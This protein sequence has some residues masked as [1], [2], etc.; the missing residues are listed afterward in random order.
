MLIEKYPLS[1]L[2]HVTWLTKK[3]SYFTDTSDTDTF[4]LLCA[5]YRYRYQELFDDD[6]RYEHLCRHVL[7]LG[8]HQKHR[9]GVSSVIKVQCIWVTATLKGRQALLLSLMCA[10]RTEDDCLP[11]TQTRCVHRIGAGSKEFFWYRYESIPAVLVDTEYPV[12]VSPTGALTAIK[13]E[14][15]TTVII[16]RWPLENNLNVWW[17]KVLHI[18][19]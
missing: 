11:H 9:T 19:I 12:P 5:E 1:T 18:E 7:V 16:T 10:V 13:P 3:I 17:V 2:R 14:A 15:T 4:G 8:R 6:N